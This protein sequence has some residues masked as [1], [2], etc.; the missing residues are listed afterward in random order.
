MG[1]IIAFV[2]QKGGVGKTTSAL[3]IASFLALEGYTVLLVDM[4][5]QANATSG[6]G[7]NPRLLDRGIYEAIIGEHLV[8]D[9]VFQTEQELMHIAPSTIH[10]AGAT[11][12]LVSEE[13]REY[14]LDAALADVSPYYDYIIIDCPPA[15]GLL[16]INALVA[17]REVIIPVQAEYYALEGLSQLL[18]TIELIQ[19]HLQPELKITGAFLTMVDKRN[20]LA[21]EVIQELHDHFPGVVFETVIPRNVALAEAPSHGKPIA[22]YKA[23][24]RGGKSYKAL[25]SEIISIS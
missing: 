21:Q 7:I 9:I 6:L 8:R 19:Q 23:R 4:D 5:P 24:S 17:A 3:N 13:K 22:L 18:D 11:V 15:L 16:T 20:A 2:N 1:R 10:L 25:T 14:K 12:E